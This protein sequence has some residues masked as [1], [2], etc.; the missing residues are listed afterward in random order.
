MYSS[1]IPSGIHVGIQKYTKITNGVVNKFTKI[2]SLN[3]M[4]KQIYLV[5]HNT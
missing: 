2:Q 4:Q 1:G 5:L 3:L